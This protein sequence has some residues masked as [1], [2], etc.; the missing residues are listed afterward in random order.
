MRAEI[1]LPPALP[2]S[3][4]PP[5]SSSNARPPLASAESRS[6][7]ASSTEHCA[8][9]I[10]RAERRKR[11]TVGLV[12]MAV[13]ALAS[14]LLIADGAPRWWR[15]MLILPWWTAALGIFQARA[16]V[17]VAFA[18]RGVRNLGGAPEPQPPAELDAIRREARRVHLRALLAAALLTALTVAWP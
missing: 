2:A 8:I 7:A 10:G 18:A 4:N 1:D 13:C 16:Q 9:N 11:L 5:V 14:V 6:E 15:L 17:C 12:A 3:Y